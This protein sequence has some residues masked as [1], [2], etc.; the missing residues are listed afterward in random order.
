M[1]A[2]NSNK[3]QETRYSFKNEFELD[4]P[5]P[6]IRYAIREMTKTIRI[7]NQLRPHLSC[8]MHTP[9]TMHQHNNPTPK[10]LKINRLWEQIFLNNFN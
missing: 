10:K 9:E 1:V 6:T 7:Y 4:K 3:E 5:L 8:G 2:T